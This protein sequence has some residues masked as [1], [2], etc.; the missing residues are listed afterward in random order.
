MTTR[1]KVKNRHQAT[2]RDYYD[3]LDRKRAEDASKSCANKWDI[4]NMNFGAERRTKLLYWFKENTLC[5]NRKWCILLKHDPDLRRMLKQG[6]L[7]RTREGN[8]STRNTYL[9]LA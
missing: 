5:V 4:L 6:I 9:S 8:F 7:K 2:E 3:N 1:Q